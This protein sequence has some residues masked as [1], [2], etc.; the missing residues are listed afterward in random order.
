MKRRIILMRHAKSSWKS[1]ALDDHSRPLNK[2]GRKAAPRVGARLAELGWSPDHIVSSDSARTVETL[3]LMRDPLE[4]H[5][6]VLLTR[7]LYLA[8]IDAIRA[9]VS[10][11]EE[12]VR[13]VMLLGHNPGFEEALATLTGEEHPLKTA[14]AALLSLDDGSWHDAIARARAWKLERLIVARDLV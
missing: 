3:M 6:D 12:S 2:R 1:D 13:T 11:L 10:D 7:N 9:L 8:G 5:G 4:Y 14:N